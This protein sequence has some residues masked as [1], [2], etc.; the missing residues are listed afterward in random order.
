MAVRSRHLQ[1]AARRTPVLVVGPGAI[2]L[3][4]AA[5]LRGAGLPVAILARDA[6]VERR[7]V[8]KGFVVTTPDGSRRRVTGLTSA[9]GLKTPVLVAFFCVKSGDAR[10]AVDTARNRI[11]PHTTVVAIQNGIGH[12][13]VFRGIFGPRRTVIGV[14]YFAADRI[15]FNQL[16]L[17]GGADILLA[18]RYRNERAL[19][20]V[21]VLLTSANF[22]VHLKDSEESMLW[23]KAVFNAAVNPLGAACAVE[24]GRIEADS[25]LREVALVALGEAAAASG[26]RLDYSDMPDKLMLSC[27]NAPHQRNSMLQDLAAGRHTEARAILGPLLRAAKRRH[28][29]TPTLEI[30]SAVISRLERQLA[31]K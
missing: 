8:R 11:G 3:S 23:T 14:C 5:G 16:K 1:E 7:L 9:R 12:E 2:G 4:L 19:E 6:V 10:R 13:K 29:P 18:R 27:R 30:L 17:N 26:R 20:T 25:A 21:R 22:R 31:K 28:V 15:A 24:S